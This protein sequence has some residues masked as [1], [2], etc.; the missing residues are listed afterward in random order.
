M[1]NKLARW[2]LQGY[3]GPNARRVLRRLLEL[4]N[5]VPPRVGAA[6]FGTIWNRWTTSRRFQQRQSASN[7]CVFGCSC[8][9]ED[10]IEHYLHCR[11]I[12]EFAS[13]RLRLENLSPAALLLSSDDMRWNDGN[14]LTRVAILV[15]CAFRATQTARN[16]SRINVSTA[17]QLLGQMLKEAVR[18]HEA[19]ARVLREVWSN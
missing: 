12:R 2:E 17:V 3:P 14:A 15:Y 4:K 19:S 11:V 9:A 7:T 6:C 18:D 13:S 8:S 16:Y 5:L 1:R 10:S